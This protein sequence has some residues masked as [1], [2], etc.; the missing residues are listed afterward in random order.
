MTGKGYHHL[1]TDIDGNERILVRTYQLKAAYY[2]LRQYMKTEYYRQ[3][4][5]DIDYVGE[6]MSY[7]R[8]EIGNEHVQIWMNDRPWVWVV[9]ETWP[10]RGNEIRLIS[11]TETPAK[12]LKDYLEHVYEDSLEP[13]KRPVV[14]WEKVRMNHDF[15]MSSYCA[16]KRLYSRNYRGR[17]SLKK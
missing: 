14:S 1:L 2:A 10:D 12:Q 6:A 8:S 16:E 17:Q 4:T 15:G 3:D 9:M 11:L 13:R 7:L 5:S